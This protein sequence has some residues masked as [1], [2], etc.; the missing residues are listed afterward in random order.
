MIKLI[1]CLLMDKKVGSCRWPKWY[2]AE[3]IGHVNQALINRSKKE[4]L[5]PLYCHIGG[6]ENW[7]SGGNVIGS[8]NWLFD[9]CLF[10]VYFTKFNCNDQDSIFHFSN[11]RYNLIWQHAELRYR[12]DI[13]GFLEDENLWYVGDIF[14]FEGQIYCRDSRNCTEWNALSI[15]SVWCIEYRNAFI[16]NHFFLKLTRNRPI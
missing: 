14:T 16:T 2:M 15:K 1:G 4:R 8:G 10:L 3:F 12:M 13:S 5:R 6:L 7:T 9:K 11:L